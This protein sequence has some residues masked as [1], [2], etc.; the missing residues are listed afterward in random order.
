MEMLIGGREVAS[1]SG[2]WNDVANPADGGVVGRVPAGNARDVETA[3]AAAVGALAAWS[4]LGSRGR[5]R[6]LMQGAAAVRQETGRLASELTTEQGK[7]LAEARNEVQGFANVLEYY[8]SISG[9]TTGSAAYIP[10]YGYGM[11]LKR[12]LGICGAIIP[13]NMPA[14]IMAWKLGPAL[15]AGN[16]LV[17]KPAGSTPLTALSL[18]SVLEESGLPPGVLNIVTGSGPDVGEAI[19]LTPAIRKL[20]FTGSVETGRHVA[21]LAAVTMKRLTLELGGS[22]PMIVCADADLEAAVAGAVRGRFYNCGQ[23]CTAIKRIFVFNEVAD[24]FLE[25][26]IEKVSALVLGDGAKAGTDLGP[27]HSREQ[28]ETVRSQLDKSIAAG[29]RPIA[30]GSGHRAGTGWFMEPVIVADP[31]PGSPVLTEEVFGP[32]LPVVR[33]NGIDEAIARANDTRYGLGASVWTGRIEMARRAFEELHAGIVW[34]NQHLRLP[35]ELPFGG[36]AGS[37]LGMENGPAA[38][39]EY[40]ESRVLLAGP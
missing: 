18:G 38:L 12:P 26:L 13:W 25:M 8:A 22:D 31:A 10:S 24:A 21:S 16:T 33:V 27:L 30:C 14:L 37:G 2:R 19:A 6:V 17:L 23:T 28:R 34:V 40:L 4:A 20:S 29:G 15:A 36:A 9:T 5:S 1:A 7:P 32:V 11:V 35:P 3:A 39:D